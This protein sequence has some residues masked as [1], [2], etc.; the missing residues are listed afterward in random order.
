MI[1]G[2]DILHKMTGR[3]KRHILSMGATINKTFSRYWSSC[4]NVL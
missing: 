3:H 2:V 1:I 4:K